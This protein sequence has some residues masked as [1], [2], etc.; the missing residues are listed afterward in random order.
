[1]RYGTAR[2]LR[3]AGFGDVEVAALLKLRLAVEEYLRGRAD[4]QIAQ[5]IVDRAASEPWF[6]LA[7]VRRVLPDPGS[8]IDMDF[9]PEPILRC[10]RCPV[11]LFYGDDD[12]WQP[13]EESIATWER[14]TAAS[15]NSDVTI[16]RLPGTGH[17]PTLREKDTVSASPLYTETLTSWIER[18][19]SSATTSSNPRDS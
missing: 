10:V 13:I 2:Q 16:L 8:W 1:M 6:D 7:W 15:G 19:I 5:D 17:E 14:A 18:R 4:R 3:R 12:E 9:D 11:L